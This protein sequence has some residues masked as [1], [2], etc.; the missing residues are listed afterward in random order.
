MPARQQQN[1]AVSLLTVLT[2]GVSAALAQKVSYGPVAGA[3]FSTWRGTNA[4]PSPDYRPG[5]FGGG[6]VTLGIYKHVALEAQVLYVRKGM[7]LTTTTCSFPNTCQPYAVSWAQDFIEL[8]LLFSVAVPTRFA[9]S[10]F[11]GPAVAFLTSCTF[12]A[13]TPPNE[14]SCDSAL[15]PPPGPASPPP[16]VMGHTDALVV[17]GGGFHLGQLALVAR[18]DLGLTKFLHRQTTYFDQKTRAWLI[19]ASV[20]LSRGRRI[21]EQ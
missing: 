20:D 12:H 2:L 5:F 19:G 18:Y 13:S 1:I 14:T 21:T 9:P 16:V 6:F 11:A 3:A 8:P 4:R 7:D 10:L 17:F 15:T